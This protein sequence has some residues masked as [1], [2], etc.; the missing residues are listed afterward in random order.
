[1]V[2]I[3]NPESLFPLLVVLIIELLT[4]ILPP[5]GPENYHHYSPSDKCNP[6]DELAVILPSLSY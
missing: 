1:M 5:C 4:T 6:I 3:F 2:G